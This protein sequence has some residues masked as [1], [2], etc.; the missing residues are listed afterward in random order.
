V[1]KKKLL[2][3]VAVGILGY[4]SW[5]ML[6][7]SDWLRDRVRER[8]IVE[9]EKAT[10]GKA[11]IG[12]FRF[13]PELLGAT[14]EN[15]TLRGTEGSQAAPLFTATRI[16]AGLRVLSFLK[17][18]VDLRRLAII[19]PQINIILDSQGRSNL[20]SPASA[21]RA[22]RSAFAT[23][24]SLAIEEFAVTNGEFNY[25]DTRTPFAVAAKNLETKLALDGPVYKGSVASKDVLLEM[26]GMPALPVDLRA[27]LA[28]RDG[29]V[30]LPKFEVVSV[31]SRVDGAGRVV[32]ADSIGGEFDLK[33]QTDLGESTRLFRFIAGRGALHS[34]GK[35][36]WLGG[37][38]FQYD[39]DLN[40]P[41]LDI[42][43]R[44]L[45]MNPVRVTGRIS[46]NP[47]A[48]TV[49]DLRADSP[50]GQFK[51]RAALPKY[52]RVEVD[53]DIA[54]FSLANIEARAGKSLGFSGRVAGPVHLGAPFGGP[55]DAS[56]DLAITPAEGATAIEGRLRA[57][58][59]GATGDISFGD[60]LLITPSSRVEFSGTLNQ[61]LR[62]KANLTSLDDLR[63]L[64]VDDRLAVK[65]DSGTVE[66]TG[67]VSGTARD[68]LAAGQL[69]AT[70]AVYE[71]SKFDSVT[72]ALIASPGK[73]TLTRVTAAQG[74]ANVSGT[75]TVTLADWRANQS[76][77]IDAR[78][79][80]RGVNL[81]TVRE[82]IGIEERIDG[83]V[84]A[85]IRLTGSVGDPR[86]DIDA[87]WFRPAWRGETI[88]RLRFKAA[89]DGSRV[90]VSEFEATRG[91]AKLNGKGFYVRNGAATI[92]FALAG[93]DL[94]TVPQVQSIRSG[95]RAAVQASGR[96]T[97]QL[98]GKEWQVR[99]A[100]A[101]GGLSNIV[102]DGESFGDLRLN[103]TTRANDLS[104]A[105]DGTLAG[106]AI[107]GT[108]AW[109]LE[110]GY[111]G[112]ARMEFG[113]M[114]FRVFQSLRPAKVAAE[115]WPFTGG[116]RGS[117]DFR[118]PLLDVD[119]WRV[120]V[121]L[122][123]LFARTTRGGAASG[124]ELRNDGPVVFSAEGRTIQIR[125]ARFVGQDTNLSVGGTF[126]LAE[127]RPWDL[128][129]NGRV[130]LAGLRAYSQDFVATGVATMQT[131]VRGEL[132]S[133]QVFGSL[134]L[135]DATLN[136]DGV[137]NGLDKVTGRVLFD[138]RRA[139]IQD[140]LTAQSGGGELSLA[141]FFD[142]A[143]AET[144]YRLQA[145]ASRVRIRYPEGVST[146]GDA[147]LTLTGAA[148][149]SLLAGNITVLRSGFTP[150]IDLGGLLAGAG[151]AQAAPGEPNRFLANMQLDVKVRTAPDTQF[152][153]S[154]TNDLQAE[155][156]LQV[157]GVG[158]R[159]VVLGRVS[160]SQGDVNFFGNKYSIK[161]GE[162]AFYN[163]ATIE[164]TLDMDLETRVRGVNVTV[165]FSGPVKKLNVSYRSDPPLQPSEIIALLTVG[166][167]PTSATVGTSQSSASGSFLESGGNSL[168]GSA[169]SAP[170]SSQLQRFFGVSR[171]KIDPTISGLDSTPQARV[172][173]EQQVSKD[174]T[175]TFVTNLN[176]SQQQVVRLE[177][178]MSREWSLIALRD[179]N[180]AFGLDFQVRKQ[181]R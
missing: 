175:M 163:P 106:A 135:K 109:K 45:R 35:F 146:V 6:L 25:A 58:Y 105:I 107:R 57:A 157:R 28:V 178:N 78:V 88:D 42:A 114:P 49:T 3:L 170:L 10:G 173:V 98:A 47:D 138:R 61:T 37:P 50:E 171:I 125:G 145:Q 168:L 84:N 148:T 122:P 153:T 127:K 56:G 2:A 99:A 82:Q 48:L 59:R 119:K 13:D 123:E 160:I 132:A 120:A 154:L 29:A 11:S 117:V 124:F 4:G 83:L 79:D 147:N 140:K 85:S 115:E 121:A 14:I 46:A 139:T 136:V 31:A 90:N 100:E 118:G 169:I 75:A 65:L 23:I 20:P 95:V 101:R 176:R 26:P 96:V 69:R 167:S 166:R 149:R 133:P 36:Q 180:G 141:G 150:R 86:G 9:V 52:K 156:N 143:S 24:L 71:K 55:I 8:A 32:Y 67:T 73:L 151:R 66:F 15:F 110:A 164:P 144:F 38:R 129:V 16:D 62:V 17:K 131:S 142:F 134:E 174:V 63:A 91:A 81:S 77:T 18:D 177:W 161:R 41:A 94:A 39:G 64:G 33:V 155:A 74:A 51:G 108:S 152:T 87:D 162:V 54:E 93:L 130:N 159:P 181:V 112:S 1:K 44:G 80:A 137:P 92:D 19:G 5:W 113:Q 34:A 158:S 21:R 72:A 60:S 103:A 104:V 27:D 165:N 22:D 40:A 128:R 111:P 89:Y 97:A 179:E 70:N 126:S 30:E 102:I 7:R 76:S 43:A 116:F 68:P 172:T 53:G 12:S